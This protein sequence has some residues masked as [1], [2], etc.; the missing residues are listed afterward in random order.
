MSDGAR[1]VSVVTANFNHGHLIE[2]AIA[3]VSSQSRKVVEHIIVDDASTDDSLSVIQ[4]L[5]LKYP[6]VRVLSNPRNMGPAM[7]CGRAIHEAKGEY[8]QFLSADDT[9]PVDS[10]EQRLCVVDG[11]NDLALICGDVGYINLAT[12]A[13]DRRRYI[14]V[15]RPIYISPRD[16]VV[17]Q[18][19]GLNV[20]NGGSALAR[21]EDLLDAKMDDPALKW[22]CDTIAYNAIAYRRGVWYVPKLLHRFT[23]GKGNFSR[24]SQVWSSQKEVLS[25]VFEL[26]ATPE[27]SDVHDA[28]RDSAVLAQFP[29]ILKFLASHP[30]H[31]D[32]LTAA[33]VKKSLAYSAYRKLRNVIPKAAI[34]DFVKKRTHST[35]RD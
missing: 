31:R 26:L 12:G 5:A 8:V 32:F 1:T 22:H 2:D 16:L 9:L 13:T 27:F 20:V 3:S 28:F 34:R 35:L 24:G 18:R 23:V 19:R 10:I 30:Q 33:I 25:R 15:D 17:Q 21:R 11:T 7:S 29:H 14:E 6:F 4:R